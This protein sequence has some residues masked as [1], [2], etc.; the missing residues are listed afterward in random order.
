L[1]NHQDDNVCVIFYDNERYDK[2]ARCAFQSF[3]HFHDKEVA[4][5][6]V[7]HRNIH[8]IESSKYVGQVS[9]G[10]LKY[11][12]CHEIFVKSGAKKLI[13]LGADTITCSRLDEFL[14]NNED[15]LATLD[16]PYQLQTPRVFSPDAETHVNADVVC[17]NNSNA[18]IDVINCA[19]HHNVYFEQGGLNEVLWSGRHDHF[20]KKIVDYPYRESNVVYNARSKGNFCAVT[21][22]KPW[23]EFT[24]KFHVEN[25]KLFTGLHKNNPDVDKQ[26][27]VFHYCEGLGTLGNEKFEELVNDWMILYFNSE[28]KEFLKKITEYPEFF[29][30]K[31]KI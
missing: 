4:T 15:I 26:I 1:S 28:T 13:S 5:Y 20:T 24:Q 6:V 29:D 8:E 22:T 2:L 25:D 16:Y 11:I 9:P 31:F 27:K 19:I 17:F 12:V 18:L 7:N 30:E 23:A 10:I 14:D 21:N 3:N